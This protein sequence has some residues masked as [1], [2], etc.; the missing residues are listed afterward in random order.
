MRDTFFKNRVIL[1]TVEYLELIRRL[2]LFEDLFGDET[3]SAS[4]QYT[5]GRD[6]YDSNERG[7]DK[8]EIQPGTVKNA[9][10][11]EKNYEFHFDD[12]ILRITPL[13]SHILKVTWK[14]CD[15]NTLIQEIKEN[16]D[17]ISLEEKGGKIRLKMKE[18]RID[19]LRNGTV[20][21][22]SGD[23][24]LRRDE[25]P[26]F[27]KKGSKLKS[28]IRSGSAIYG[29]GEKALGL[30]MRGTRSLLWNHD[31]NGQYGPDDD[32]LY[33]SYPFYV[34]IEESNGYFVFYNN[35]SRG[36]IDICFSEENKVEAEFQDGGLEY[37]I[38][39]G[40]LKQITE[41]YAKIIGL[42]PL[43]AKWALGFHQSRYSYM[44]STEIKAIKDN[45]KKNELPISCIHMDI[46][47]MDG[48]R[49]FTFNPQTFGNV[50]YLSSELE[51]DGVKLV[52]I[53]DPAVKFD[54]NY[55][56]FTEGMHSDLFVHAPD[57]S[58]LYAP[59]WAGMSA[60]PDFS[61]AETRKWWSS[62][63]RSFLE[64]GISGFWHDMN[65]PAAFTLWG[66]NTLPDSALFSIG[67][68]A[69]SHNLY[70][71]YMA[72]AGYEGILSFKPDE[73]P[74]ILSRSGWA[75]IQRY[76]F[77]WTGDTASTWA[78]M[79]STI[80]TLLNMGLSGIQFAGVD[81]GGFSGNP[82]DE[83]FLRWFQMATFFP[84]FRV[85]SAK[86]TRMREPWLFGKKNLEILRKFLSLRY[87][88]F[89]YLY[90]LSYEAH[91]TGHPIVRPASWVDPTY[92]PSAD[93]VFT[94]GDNLFIAPVL[95]K[96]QRDAIIMLPSGKWFNFWDSTQ[97]EGIVKMNLKEDEIPV[98]VKAG[99]ILSLEQ[100]GKMIMHVYNSD[101]C[102]G[103]L[104]IDDGKKDPRSVE[105]KFSCRKVKD[106]FKFDIGKVDRGFSG[107]DNLVFKFHGIKIKNIESKNAILNRKDNTISVSSG[108]PVLK[109]N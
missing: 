86:G 83:L 99:S 22:Y 74:F 100:D 64:N 49:V 33:L 17:E 91:L 15:L 67:S 108:E 80:S 46:D 19:I 98:F 18:N 8:L 23:L 95:T 3:A 70:G 76:A 2:K 34:D 27:G 11:R 28:S 92:D 90:T 75:G 82:S 77:V 68:H 32:P 29:L 104:Y 42:P 79:H 51:K 14:K 40:N 56:L 65:E 58:I 97:Y 106:G 50:K 61:K 35:P 4:L 73:R 24:L 5:L 63:Y 45:F 41:K 94:L 60:F 37:F 7:K 47:Y 84:F 101:E 78:E 13:E 55:D 62:K 87:S 26:L 12:L 6:A 72:L 31:A 59:V 10:K 93:S 48:Y 16:D 53:I 102:S 88:L 105:F 96:N 36:Y 109:F 103:T 57:G 9:V 69:S 52:T 39:F 71:L 38:G 44:D 54:M 1:P 85:H 21:F 81:V 43:P 25:P 20:E 30:N 107:P 89:P 66:D